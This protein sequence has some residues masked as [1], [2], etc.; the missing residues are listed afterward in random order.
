MHECSLQNKKDHFR[1]EMNLLPLLIVASVKNT[2]R[3]IV[4]GGSLWSTNSK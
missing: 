1:Y 4:M 3:Y 2:V